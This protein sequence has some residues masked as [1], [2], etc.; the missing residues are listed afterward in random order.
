M[1]FA[2]FIGSLQV[3]LYR[4]KELYLE[5]IERS[6]SILHDI[7]QYYKVGVSEQ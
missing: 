4:Q 5:L 6:T 2:I 3:N 7:A 1:G